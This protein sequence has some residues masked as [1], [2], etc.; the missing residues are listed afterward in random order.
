MKQDEALFDQSLAQVKGGGI[1][2]PHQK[3]KPRGNYFKAD[4]PPVVSQNVR[5]KLPEKDDEEDDM[6]VVDP[7][8]ELA[9]EEIERMKIKH[10]DE[11][12]RTKN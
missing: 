3:I 2:G 12:R 10:Q 6:S 9:E 5:V 4:N 8:A 11:M 7:E 1:S